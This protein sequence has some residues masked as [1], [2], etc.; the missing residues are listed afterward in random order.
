MH[1]THAIHQKEGN[2][3]SLVCKIL[4]TDIELSGSGRSSAVSFW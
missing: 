2:V 4:I 3:F 1:F